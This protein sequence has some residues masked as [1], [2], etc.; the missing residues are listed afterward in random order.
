MPFHPGAKKYFEEQG[1]KFESYGLEDGGR[2]RCATRRAAPCHRTRW[3]PMSES[4]RSRAEPS[5]TSELARRAFIEQEEGAA[6]RFRGWL[7]H[8]T[9]TLLVVMSLFHLYAAVEIV[10]AQVLRPVHVGFVLLLVFLLF[11]IARRFRNRLM[12]WDVVC[13]RARRRDDRV[14]ARRRR[15]HLG[16]QHAADAIGRVLRRRVRAARARSVPAHVGLDHAVRGLPRSSPTPSSAPGCPGSGS[17][18][19]TTSR[20]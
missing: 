4:A 17:T 3:P 15:R 6:S 16:P 11:P 14:P 12:W 19:A 2:S 20:A 7:G 18:A 1:V 10:P 5:S 13:A 9:T 8:V